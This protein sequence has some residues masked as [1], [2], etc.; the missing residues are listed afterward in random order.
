MGQKQAGHFLLRL[1]VKLVGLEGHGIG[2]ILGGV[3]V[4]AHEDLLGARVGAVYIV[5]V[6]GGAELYA[7]LPCEL[8]L[9]RE[10]TALLLIAVILNLDIVVVAEEGFIPL[11]ALL[12]AVVVA[13]CKLSCNLSGEAGGLISCPIT[14][15]CSARI[16]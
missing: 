7:E 11:G 3:G 1:K 9:V 13:V 5:A 2:G 12:G 4:Y 8:I 16:P 6:V 15:F 10:Y 14:L